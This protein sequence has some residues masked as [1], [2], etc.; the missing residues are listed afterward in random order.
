MACSYKI[1]KE[2]K[3]IIS[4]PIEGNLY[5]FNWETKEEDFIEFLGRVTQVGYQK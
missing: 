1:I 4:T 2:K 3:M 5:M